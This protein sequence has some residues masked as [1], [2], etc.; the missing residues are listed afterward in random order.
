MNITDLPALLRPT[1]GELG[2][3]DYEKAFCPDLKSGQDIFDMR[4]INR[5]KGC[6][7]IVRPDQYVAHILP[8]DAHAELAEFFSNILLLPIYA[9]LSARKVVSCGLNDTAIA[10]KNIASG[11]TF[12]DSSNNILFEIGSRKLLPSGE[13]TVG[14]CLSHSAHT[15]MLDLARNN[16]DVKKFIEQ[17]T[18]M[19]S[20]RSDVLI[21]NPHYKPIRLDTG[22]L[23]YLDRLKRQR[24]LDEWSSALIQ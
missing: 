19:L 20:L 2:L 5:N 7:V 17:E 15:Q 21:D 3:V 8:L 12:G 14:A 11:Q 10:F 23:V 6:V 18:D 4:G 1:K 22:L 16:D 24:F 13:A 9:L